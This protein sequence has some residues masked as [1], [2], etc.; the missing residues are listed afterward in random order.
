M[1]RVVDLPT[2]YAAGWNLAQMDR[3]LRLGWAR[4]L[5]RSGRLYL[6]INS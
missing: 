6:E 4:L 5:R 2:A 1:P 3:Y